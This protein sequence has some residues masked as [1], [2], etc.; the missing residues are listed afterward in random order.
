[1]ASSA[2]EAIKSVDKSHSAFD[3]HGR[4]GAEVAGYLLVRLS[5]ALLTVLQSISSV[6]SH[7][8]TSEQLIS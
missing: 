8:E 4:V 3:I 1:M 6:L 2:V 5:L 7:H